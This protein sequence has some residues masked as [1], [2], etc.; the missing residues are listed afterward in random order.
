MFAY[1]NSAELCCC[2]VSTEEKTLQQWHR[3]RERDGPYI[4]QD[5]AAVNSRGLVVSADLHRFTRER[6]ENPSFL[7][8][9]NPP[10]HLA[11]ALFAW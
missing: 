3:E 8:P 11:S 9:P 2:I 4:R 5:V 6:T 1:K 7:P 10:D